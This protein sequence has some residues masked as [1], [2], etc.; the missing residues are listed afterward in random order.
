[1]WMP[2]GFHSK[3]NEPKTTPPSCKAYQW[4]FFPLLKNKNK[5]VFAIRV[6][7]NERSKG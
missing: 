5:K 7:D 6:Q 1:M 4:N 2:P 3:I